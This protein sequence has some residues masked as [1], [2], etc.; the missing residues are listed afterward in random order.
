MKP[1][2]VV[3]EI[4]AKRQARKERDEAAKAA[5]N[6][7]KRP[8]GRPRGASKPLA[9]VPAPAGPGGG[10]SSQVR[11]SRTEPIMQVDR[12]GEGLRSG[13]GSMCGGS[14]VRAIDFLLK[15]LRQLRVE[16]RL[17]RR[18]RDAHA[19]PDGVGADSGCAP[20]FL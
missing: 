10:A 7:A 8:V 4:E 18:G 2:V 17:P 9:D 16:G 1:V 20:T 15:G 6:A 19:R 12:R 3:A 5:A 11:T 13:G 14:D